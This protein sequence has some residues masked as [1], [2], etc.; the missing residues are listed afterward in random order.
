MS[1][2]K[3]AHMRFIN[4]VRE[5]L[6]TCCGKYKPYNGE[7]FYELPRTQDMLD[8]Y[9]MSCVKAN[10]TLYRKY[11]TSNKAKLALMGINKAD[12]L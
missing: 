4:G 11:G 9:C 2:G 3:T 1:K 5:K 8:H 6:C 10:N 7:H 12:Y